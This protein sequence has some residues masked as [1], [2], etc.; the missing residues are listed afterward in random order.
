[1]LVMRRA[2][3][4][5]RQVTRFW[6]FRRVRTSRYMPH[7]GMQEVARRLRHA[8]RIAQKE[9]ERTDRIFAALIA[10]AQVVKMTV[11]A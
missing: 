8:E 2:E 1:M 4:R 6:S 9:R 3:Q 7:M 11:A 10:H 5:S